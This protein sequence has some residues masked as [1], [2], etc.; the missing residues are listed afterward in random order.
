MGL[1]R[2]EK[3]EIIDLIKD[4]FS[5]L[6]A[7]LKSTISQEINKKLDEKLKQF[8]G[9][10]EKKITDLVDKNV[11]LHDKLDALEQYT[12]RNSIR[13]YGVPEQPNEDTV[14][15][16]KSVFIDNL[17]L[18]TI[19]NMIDRCHR[20][21]PRRVGSST[22]SKPSVIIIKFISYT[23]K[24]DL[25]KHAKLLKGTGFSV[26]D[27]LTSIRYKLYKSAIS[28]FGRNNTWVLDGNIFVKNNGIRQSIKSHDDLEKLM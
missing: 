11:S 14:D 7:D 24:H 21:K 1:S 15:L 9:S 19:C 13:L 5:T 25:R 23:A 4:T 20:L 28:K 17:N 12:R 2:S 22:N 8:F 10:M 3:S 16:V 27:D 6:T 26:A 18:P